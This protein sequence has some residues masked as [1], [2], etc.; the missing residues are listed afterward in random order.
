M[1]QA[2]KADSV[3]VE[4]VR[5]V[6]AAARLIAPQIHEMG[7]NMDTYPTASDITHINN[8]KYVCTKVP[9]ELTIRPKT[10]RYW[11]GNC[12]GSPATWH[13]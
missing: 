7:D 2:E 11:L 13:T 6:K 9:L 8:S 4:S 5:I 3:Q 10:G 12:A 1:V